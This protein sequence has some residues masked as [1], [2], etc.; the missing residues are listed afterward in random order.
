MRHVNIQAQIG[1]AFPTFPRYLGPYEVFQAGT[2]FSVP[3]FDLTL[4]RR[5]QA[6][7]ASVTATGAEEQTVREQIA[8]LVVSQY[9]GGLRAAEDV[10]A[11]QSRVD[12]AQALF[13]QATDLKKTGVGTG[14][15]A[16]RANVELQNET[17]RLINAQTQLEDHVVRPRAPAE[18]Q[19]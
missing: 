13:D 15:D 7:K 10:R 5:W 11:A 1:I 9:L 19:A 18:F 3:I 8:A 12:L 4:W 17:Q 16:L 2:G 6:S 14:I